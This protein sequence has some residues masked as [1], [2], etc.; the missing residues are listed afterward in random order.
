MTAQIINLNDERLKRQ[1]QAAWRKMKQRLLDDNFKF[2]W[3]EMPTDFNCRCV[4]YLSEAL[5]D[6]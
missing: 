4:V 1:K 3:G 6:D 5:K 2:R